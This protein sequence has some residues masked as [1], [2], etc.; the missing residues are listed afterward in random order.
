MLL[1]T[2]SLPML[3][4]PAFSL[5]LLHPHHAPDEHFWNKLASPMVRAEGINAFLID[6]SMKML[7]YPTLQIKKFPTV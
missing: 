4:N 7:T 1:Q 3:K 5:G 6:F 2:G